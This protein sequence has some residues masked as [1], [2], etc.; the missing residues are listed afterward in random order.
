MV[1]G[2]LSLSAIGRSGEGSTGSRHR[3]VVDLPASLP[4]RGAVGGAQVA[5]RFV[6]RHRPFQPGCMMRLQVNAAEATLLEGSRD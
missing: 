6:Q 1:A 3:F 4:R 5:R 2:Q